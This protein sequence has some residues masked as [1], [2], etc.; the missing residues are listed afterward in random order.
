MSAL[1]NLNIGVTVNTEQVPKALAKVETQVKESAARMSKVRASIGAIGGAIGAGPLGGA[2]S[3]LGGQI[4]GGLGVGLAG[5]GLAF[6]FAQRM[7][8][9]VRSSVKG[10]AAALDEFR[11]TGEQTFAANSV[12]LQR[13][14]QMEASFGQGQRGFGAGFATGISGGEAFQYYGLSEMSTQI[15]AFVGGLVGSMGNLQDAF[16]AAALSIAGEG[17]AQ[18][19]EKERKQRE[20]LVSAGE[21]SD[22]SLGAGLYNPLSQGPVAYLGDKFVQNSSILQWAINLIA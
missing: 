3:A 11:K 17:V 13:Q 10:A 18:Q 9:E 4:G 15:G 2:G 6:G 21:M 19:M 1:P 16:D 5:A 14:A 20:K 12:I 7:E 8:Q 22:Y